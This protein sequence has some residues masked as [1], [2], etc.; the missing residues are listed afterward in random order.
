MR[1][2]SPA[3]RPSSTRC[4]AICKKDCTCRGKRPLNDAAVLHSAPLERTKALHNRGK[5]ARSASPMRKPF[6]ATICL[7]LAA[8]LV[9][10]MTGLSSSLNSKIGKARQQVAGKRAKEG[11]LTTELSHYSARIQSLRGDIGE[12]QQRQDR[13]QVSLN[14]KQMELVRIAARHNA[15]Q[16]RLTV[17]RAKLAS[18][19]RL[20]A[21]RL[22]ALYKDDQPDMV[23]VVLEAHGFT[24]LLDRA[25]FIQRVSDQ[26]ETVVT[27]V[28][29]LSHEVG[30]A[31]KRLQGLEVQA[32]NARNAI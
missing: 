12:L 1:V 14:A 17:L 26:N 19:R 11:V 32:T 18:G 13:V 30:M 31:E 20:L 10:P 4:R 3:S 16:D 6:L 9:L 2:C 8:Y 27:K 21:Q 7:A 24:D 15:V 23:T 29:G 22:V 28:R 5:H 25:D